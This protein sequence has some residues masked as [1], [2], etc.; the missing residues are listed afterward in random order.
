[1]TA[2]KPSPATRVSSYSGLDSKLVAF[3]LTLKVSQ[4]YT[5]Y[6][7]IPKSREIFLVQAAARKILQTGWLKQHHL[8]LKVP[9]AGKSMAKMPRL[10]LVREDLQ[11]SSQMAIFSLGPPMGY[12]RGRSPGS[13]LEG[14]K[15]HSWQ[16]HPYDLFTP[17]SSTS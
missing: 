6:I 12:G 1:M 11:P 8:L 3:C 16:L 2:L 15:S 9:E 13:L 4:R 17:Q 5:H 14:H 7:S 10:V